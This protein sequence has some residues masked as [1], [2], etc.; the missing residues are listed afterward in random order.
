MDSKLISVVIVNW[1]SGQLLENC[2]R[3]LRKNAED[4]EIVVVDNASIDSSLRF[5]VEGGA[6]IRILR[7][8]RNIGFAAANN[9]GW[10]AGKGAFVLFLNP[11]TECLPGSVSRLAQALAAD[12]AVWAVGGH[13]VGLSG[14]SQTGFNVRTF[15]TVGRVAAEMLFLDE[16]WPG[17][18]RPRAGRAA[19]G[20]SPLDVDQPAAACLMVTRAALETAQGFDEA[21]CPAWFEDVDLCRRIRDLGGRIQ[22]HPEARFLHHGGHSL[23]LLSRRSFLESFHTNQIRYFLK[24][25]GPR[26]AGRAKKWIV[27]GLLLRSALSFA[28]PPARGESRVSSAKAYWKAARHIGGR[29]GVKT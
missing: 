20:S 18:W 21:F 11:D 7:N 8:D 28:F 3:S 12:G 10:R 22:Y 1:S 19:S 24:H 2:V 15:P 6:Q 27:L 14:E 26:S 29:R 13:L 5:T 17:T 4:C 9:I 25:H 16:I 23:S